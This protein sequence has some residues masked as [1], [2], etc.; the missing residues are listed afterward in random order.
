[1][2]DPSRESVGAF[3]DAVVKD[4]ARA[5]SMLAENPALLNA[6]WIHDETVLHFLAIEGFSEGV[7]FMA[8]R[9]ADV[10][11]VDKFGDTPLLNVAVQ[12]LTEIADILL[13]HGADPNA[14]SLTK[15]NPLHAAARCGHANLVRRLLRA[16]ANAEYRTDSGETVFDAVKESPAG[17]QAELLA[18]LN[19]AGLRDPETE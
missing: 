3:I 11:A 5:D 4:P 12:G 8:I 13:R 14:K 1:M 2:S 17:E 15:D 10:N 18:A 19:E 7:R 6:R 9:G 16:G